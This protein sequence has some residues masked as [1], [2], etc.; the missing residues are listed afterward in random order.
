MATTTA[1]E[2]KPALLFMPDISGFT[3]FVNETEILHGQHIVQ[4]LLEILMDS[5]ELNM[6]VNEVEGDAILFFRP[7]EK[8]SMEQ[9]IKQVEK[10]YFN[11]HQHLKLYDHQ[12]ICP[13][14][15]CKSAIKL[16]LKVIAHYGEVAEYFLKEHKKLFGKEVIVIHRLLKND[17]DHDE[18]FLLTDPLVKNEKME[19]CPSWFSMNE[20]MGVYDAGEIKYAYA[21]LSGLADQVPSPKFPHQDMAAKARVSFTDE[22]VVD[23]EMSNVFAAIFDLDKRTEWMDGIKKIEVIGHDKINRVGTEHRC[24]A[25]AGKN[26]VIVTEAANLQN[27]KIE[28]VEMHKSGMGGCRYVVKKEKAGSTKVHVDVLVSKNPFI[29]LMF[30]LMMKNK[31]RKSMRQSLL[32]LKSF[33]QVSPQREEKLLIPKQSGQLI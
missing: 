4:E 24:I 3:K 12:R 25:K 28:L 10:M 13:C 32:N 5:N 22:E 20:M 15:A 7:G 23:A 6:Q 8:P 11:F 19:N 18:Y 33:F 29:R 16:K 9:L 1:P 27:D 30:G 14:G 31:F 17:V 21:L 26:P 2:V